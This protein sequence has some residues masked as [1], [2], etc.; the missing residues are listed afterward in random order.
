MAKNLAVYFAEMPMLTLYHAPGTCALAVHVALEEA[1][2]KYQARR[3]DLKNNEQRSPEYLAVNPKGRVPALMT[4]HGVLTETPALLIYLAQRFPEAKLAPLDDPFA[5]ARLHEFNA[6]LASTVHVAHAHRARGYRWA[7]DPAAIEAMKA[8]VAQNM[9]DGLAL[10]ESRLDGKWVLGDDYS[11][12]DPYLFTIDRWLEGDG[13]DIGKFQR[14]KAH[15][16]RME[17]RPA[18]QRVLA[19]LA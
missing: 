17:Q 3:V 10:I 12:A 15:F 7:D 13:V 1:G 11:V 5:M 2:A 14:V 8:K 16:D 6:Y 4:E 9:S 19:A 18:V